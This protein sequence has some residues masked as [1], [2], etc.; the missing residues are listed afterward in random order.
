MNYIHVVSAE[1]Q[2][3]FRRK[4]VCI[5]E[6][7]LEYTKQ[8]AIHKGKVTHIPEPPVENGAQTAQP[9]YDKLNTLFEKHVAHLEKHPPSYF[10]LYLWINPTTA[11]G[12]TIVKK[13]KERGVFTPQVVRIFS[14]TVFNGNKT[15]M[16]SYERLL[17]DY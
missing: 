2:E 7:G 9:L 17:E 14:H 4:N 15:A 12:Y 11:Y 3:E 13:E 8:W 16:P 5:P 1:M 6:F 10:Q